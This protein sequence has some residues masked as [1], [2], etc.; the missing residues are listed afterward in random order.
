ML[1]Y[2]LD[3]EQDFSQIDI[4][5]GIPL[6]IL[7]FIRESS[8]AIFC[9]SPEKSTWIDISNNL[10]AFRQVLENSEASKATWWSLRGDP[11]DYIGQIFFKDVGIGGSWWY[12]DG[13][14]FHPSAP[15][16]LYQLSN[17]N[18]LPDTNNNTV[19]RGLIMEG[20]M[21]TERELIFDGLYSFNNN[22]NTKQLQLTVGSFSA[23][24]VIGTTAPTTNA[25]LGIKHKWCNVGAANSQRY[26][27]SLSAPYTLTSSAMSSSSIDT[28]AAFYAGV[29]IQLQNAGDTAKVDKLTIILH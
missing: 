2:F 25:S 9:P 28:S 8:R 6:P 18:A 13:Y 1:T 26:F 21:G 4:I 27:P 16:K 19:F 7:Y 12:S 17:L 3:K 24:T 22:A 11:S 10:K 23:P 15:I 20:L 29:N 5:E 14:E